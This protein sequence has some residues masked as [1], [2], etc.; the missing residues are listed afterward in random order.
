MGLQKT[1]VSVLLSHDRMGLQKTWVSVLL[2]HDRMGEY[3]LSVAFVNSH[4]EEIVLSPPC[5][6]QWCWK[7]SR[8]GL[9]C[10]ICYYH[11]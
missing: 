5:S 6:A 8:Q 4:C 3:V 11:C 7:R 10:S 1:W 9:N 2:S